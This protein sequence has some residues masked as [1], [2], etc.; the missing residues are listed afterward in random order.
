MRVCLVEGPDGVGKT[1]FINM[2]LQLNPGAIVKHFTYEDV[3]QTP[4]PVLRYSNYLRN[5]NLEEGDNAVVI[6]DRGWY[7]DAIYGSILRGK[8]DASPEEVDAIERICKGYGEL[9]IFMITAPVET[10]WKRCKA[11]GEELITD[12]DVFKKICAAYSVSL[13]KIR[14]TSPGIVYEVRT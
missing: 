6:F 3:K 2:L 12:K 5:V 1:T 8:S 13:P 9:V 7:S 10:A 11:R 14:A 4:D